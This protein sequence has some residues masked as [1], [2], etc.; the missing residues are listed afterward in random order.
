MNWRSNITVK[1]LGYLLAASIVPLVLLGVTAF[2]IAQHIVVQQ[3]ESENARLVGSFS[4]YLKLYNE[5][6]E[7]L[8]A[9]IAGNEAVALALRASDEHVSDTFSALEMRANMGRILNSYVRVKGLVSIDVF[10]IGGM[11]FHVGETL[12][13]TQ[14]DRARLERLTQEA[15]FAASPVVWRGVDDNLNTGS[16]QAKV[17]TLTRAIKLFSAATGRSDVAGLLVISLND[18]IMRSYLQTIPLAAGTQL[19]QV[20]RNGA[21]ALH[22][23][24]R[25]FAKPLA[26]ALL[27]LV[28]AQPAVTAF[29][30]N[31]EDVLM[32]V[33]PA[34]QPQQLRVVI[35]PRRL[36]NQKVN[37]LALATLGLIAL[38]GLI[39]LSLT[40]HFTRTIV[41]PIRAVSQ[42]FHRLS[43][44]HAIPS[45]PL[46]G[47]D[48]HDEIGQLIKGYNEHLEAL[49]AQRIASDELSHSEALLRA[50]E[51]Q[52]RN[53]GLQLRA[54]LDEMPVGV[55]LLDAQQRLF[56][57]NRHFHTLFGYSADETPD[58]QTWMERALPN[59][60]YRAVVQRQLRQ[61]QGVN[62]AGQGVWAP[63]VYAVRCKSGASMHVEMS[64]VGTEAGFIVTFV[65]HSQHQE[66]QLQLESAK[67][68]AEA[69]NV[70]KSSFLATMSHEIRTPMN[71]ILGMLDLLDQ[72]PLNPRQQ[73]YTS[74]AASATRALLG[75]VNDIL[76]FSKVEADKLDLDLQVF[77][78]NDLLLDLA[79][80]LTS[81]PKGK[82]LQVLFD[83][84]A[85]LPTHY[86]GDAL[87]LRQVLLNLSGNAIKFTSKGEVVLQVR[88]VARAKQT[89]ELEFSVR[90]TGIGIAADKLDYV[91]EGFSQAE[92]ST[93]RQF[94][95]TGLGLAISKRL[96]ALMGGTL[97]AHSV[98]GEGSRFFFC[99]KLP[100]ASADT[101]PLPL[102]EPLHM[103]LV[104]ANPVSST[105]LRAMVHALGWSCDSVDSGAAA[106]QCLQDAGP[107][108][109]HCVLT[110]MYLGDMDVWD[111][112]RR[113]H[114]NADDPASLPK[115]LLLAALGREGLVPRRHEDHI[116][117]HGFLAKPFT[118]PMLRDAV[119]H[120]RSANAVLG[121]RSQGR[122]RQRRLSG[123]RV[124]VVEDNLIN[125]QVAEELLSAE[126]AVVAMAANGQAGVDAVAQTVP[127]FDV[128]LMDIQMPVLDGY[129]ATR[130]IR[131]QLG[132]RLL[133]IVAMTANALSSDRDACLACG[134]NEHVGKPFD[135]HH[136]VQTLL[137][138][139]GFVPLP[140]GAAAPLAAL[141]E[142]A[143]DAAP[144]P[145]PQPAAPVPA[146]ATPEGLDLETALARMSGLDSL[147]VRAAQD[148]SLS[149]DGCVAQLRAALLAN[150]AKSAHLQLHTLKGNAATLGTTALSELAR[151]LERSC[152]EDDGVARCLEQLVALESEVVV[153]QGLLAHA[154]RSLQARAAPTPS[155]PTAPATDDDAPSD[156]QWSQALDELLKLA[157]ASD[158]HLLR[159]H[160]ELRAL[161]ARRDA[162]FTQALDA[163]LAVL[164]LPAV[165]R[166]C[167]E[168]RAQDSAAHA[169]AAPT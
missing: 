9:N 21:I 140:G 34:E 66:N 60:D 51:I 76:D 110:D 144:E 88:L 6:V 49:R 23:D 36:L 13:V 1:M 117:L 52:L 27:Q 89:A 19:M 70:A 18:E 133:P 74:K 104:D 168:Q 100:V 55:V 68:L 15:R 108:K 138:L 29:T 41:R 90:D 4:S 152:L 28:R 112:T 40:V 142:P 20:D 56:L 33:T 115:V 116:L 43:G 11:H 124:L 30:L 39:I 87:R 17:V 165:V 16:Q 92:S 103:L 141:A 135:I 127:P 8:A 95:G 14:V 137:R 80:I 59:P 75:I 121:R 12:N 47:A 24:P 132:Q 145:P 129:G 61:A 166:L 150:D 118:A 5:Q 79:F 63:T 158:L 42:G 113:M 57:R 78:L 46:P 136:L 96:V 154:I 72:T 149:L 155:A 62:A 86:I 32:E 128:V 97:R 157:L 101:L 143:P 44:N 53:S 69:A 102:Q 85:D 111:L 83:V 122:K 48:T 147:Y 31:G 77:A 130:K 81:T 125:Q 120:A 91:F 94:G 71:G 64:G 37:E 161:L 151:Q 163:A 146:Q 164:D 82:S 22:S 3:A 159:R 67:Q 50:T 160:A 106:L 156:A 131:E 10:S 2:E 84:G 93:T 119:L 26:P 153:A 167:Q 126:G 105:L 7:D 45:A 139:T 58:L 148:F 109:Y 123:M 134:M 38:G 99:L 35:T 73:D 169:A 107:G 98:L 114:D 65:D 162:P 54:I 25:Q